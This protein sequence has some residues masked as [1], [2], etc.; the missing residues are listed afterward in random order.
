M[1]SRNIELVGKQNKPSTRHYAFFDGVD[2]T[3]FVTPKLLEISMVSGTFQVGEKVNV[4]VSGAGSNSWMRGSGTRP[5]L[6][7]RVAQSNHKEGPYNAPTKTFGA[8][9]YQISQTVPVSYSATT[10][11][12]NIDTASL[13]SQTDIGAYS[14]FVEP[15]MILRG[16]SSGALATITQVRLISDVSGF[17][18]GS[19]FI[20]PE[21]TTFPSFTAG[22]KEFKLTSDPENT[23]DAD[24]PSSAVDNYTAQGILETMQETIIATRN[25]RVITQE[26][27][28]TVEATRTVGTEWQDTLVRTQRR[29]R[30]RNN[31]DP[32]AQS[33][34]VDEPEGVFVTKVD[35]FFATKDDTDLPVILTIRTMSNGTPTET[36]VP[37]SEVVMDPGDITVSNDGSVATT[38][39]FKAPVYLEGGM[40]Y[41]LVMLSNSAKYSVY[42]SRVGDNDL[43][44]NTYIANQPLLGSLF[45]EQILLNLVH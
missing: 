10:T 26:I 29:W 13:A 25:A 20:P 7:F 44:D 14:G 16:E 8:D 31:G 40:E 32:L 1:R 34:S 17:F 19:F 30:W 24:A 22:T 6:T 4:T 2:V 33:F 36:V 23:V 42:I 28:D 38:L 11:T 18:G 35:V 45:I 27:R 43:I 3:K 37:L 12:V 9:P 21:R 15:N 39:E 41:A 5:H